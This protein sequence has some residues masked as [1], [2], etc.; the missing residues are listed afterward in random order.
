MKNGQTITF[1][2][3]DPSSY[4]DYATDAQLIANQLNAQGFNVTLDGSKP[5][6]G[7][8]TARRQL[9]RDHPLE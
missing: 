4:S 8:T 9:R 7:T 3:E 2:I 5:P 6:S 1:S